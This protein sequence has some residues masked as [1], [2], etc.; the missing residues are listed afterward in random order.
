MFDMETHEKMW[1]V[2]D[3]PLLWI[4][5]LH[6][7]DTHKMEC[8]FGMK[9]GGHRFHVKGQTAVFYRNRDISER[10]RQHGKRRFTDQEFVDQFCS[11]TRMV[12]DSIG[13]LIKAINEADLK[14]E[15]DEGLLDLYLEFFDRYSSMVA[16]YRCT[17]QDF[18]GLLTEYLKEKIPEPKEEIMSMLLNNE[19]DKISLEIDQKLKA[20]ALNLHKIGR[21]RFEMH[22]TWLNSF[23]R[24]ENLFE[25]I[26]KRINLSSL[27]VKNCLSSEIKGFLLGRKKPDKEEIQKRI[28]SFMF[29][30]TDGGFRIT[31]GHEG[32]DEE[33][34]IEDIKGQCANPGKAQGRVFI[35]RESLGGV[36]AEQMRR[37]NKGDILVATNTSPDMMLAIEKASAIVTDEGG[38]LCHAA[39][40]SREFNIPCIIGTGNATKMLREGDHVSIDANKGI[41]EKIKNKKQ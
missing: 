30:Y 14:Q 2:R 21:R 13:S 15:K 35:L 4:E 8:I 33:G 40:V 34:L 12:E 39:I 19:H 37:M 1:E 41:V 3:V 38:M 5:A 36:L 16:A 20:L 27:E 24:A 17:R 7:G 18:Y 6:N 9:Y 11:H 23:I 26:G 22:G 32:G 31:T 29:E 25:E 10:A 28:S